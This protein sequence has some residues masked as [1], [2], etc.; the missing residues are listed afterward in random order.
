MM[1]NISLCKLVINSLKEWDP[2]FLI[3][4][5]VQK[6]MSL[7]NLSSLFLSKISPD[8]DFMPHRYRNIATK[9]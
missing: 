4:I 7:I 2:I 8:D 6:I 3:I 5:V 1:L 9:F